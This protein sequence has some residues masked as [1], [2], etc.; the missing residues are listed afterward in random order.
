MIALPSVETTSL[1]LVSTP[2]SRVRL[3]HLFTCKA[4]LR[5]PADSIGPTPDGLQLNFN[6]TG[7]EVAGP[8]VTGRLRA[9]GSDWLTVRPDGTGVLDLRIA[10]ETGDGA[11]IYAAF[12][13]AVDHG[14][15]GYQRA[16]Q[17]SLLRDGTLF[18]IAPRFQS[19]DTGYQWLNGLRCIGLGQVFPER[20]TA[21]CAVYAIHDSDPA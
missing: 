10:I 18:E 14:K 21:R 5:L 19:A 2:R 11:L 15:H 9:I 20:G 13:G 16:L 1:A 17:G 4:T 8:R 12:Q 7:G 3:E 6:L